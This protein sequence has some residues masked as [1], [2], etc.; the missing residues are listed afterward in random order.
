M[1]RH[2]K[3]IS[4]HRKQRVNV[5]ILFVL[6]PLFVRSMSLGI[7]LSAT[8]CRISQVR[9]SSSEAGAACAPDTSQTSDVFPVPGVGRVIDA[10]Y[11]PF[12]DE[13]LRAIVGTNVLHHIPEIERFFTEATR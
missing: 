13:S 4:T 7:H 10:R 1:G 12:E 8:H 9:L 2:E 3:T 11:L 6:T 5:V